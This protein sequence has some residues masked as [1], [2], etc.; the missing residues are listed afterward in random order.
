[1]RKRGF[2]WTEGPQNSVCV[3]PSV[4]LQK[5]LLHKTREDQVMNCME[6]MRNPV[7]Y[8]ATCTIARSGHIFIVLFML[9]NKG[10]M[11]KG[12]DLIY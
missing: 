12:V 11:W 8:H 1:M 3:L 10:N 5:V 7:L 4:N 9:F 2:D 6:G